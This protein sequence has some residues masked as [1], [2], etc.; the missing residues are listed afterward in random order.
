MNA[1]TKYGP[2][3]ATFIIVFIFHSLMFKDNPEFFLNSLI[4]PAI[5]FAMLFYM[6][7]AIFFG[8]VIGLIPTFITG[9]VFHKFFS[10]KLGTASS[11][12]AIGYGLVSSL[13]WSP[14]LLFSLDSIE[15]LKLEATFGIAVILPTSAI[16]GWLEWR[17]VQKRA[18]ELDYR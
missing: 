13:I 17:A 14:L 7:L 5:L 3:I 16:C 11:K 1:Y 6:V 15:M 18:F 12:T 9:L 4:D 8:Y 10:T 2:L